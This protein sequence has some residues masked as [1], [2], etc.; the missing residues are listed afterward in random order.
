MQ[1]QTD[2]FC[3]KCGVQNVV[4]QIPENDNRPRQTC[5][6]C[7]TIFYENPRVIVGV[8]TTYQDQFLLCK[9]AI[10]PQ[11][12]LWTY[13]AG[14]LENGESI[15][16]GAIREA[17]EESE[18]KVTISRLLGTYTL[19]AVNQV[20]LIFSGVMETSHHAPT[21]ESSEVRLFSE[22][23]IPWNKLAFP[24]IKWALKA[25]I[26]SQNT[27]DYVVDSISSTAGY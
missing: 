10:E 16:A 21:F 5:L 26:N 12:G 22:A 1:K 24:V 15:E 13:P 4:Y 25:H 2:L 19:Q 23:E 7:D 14:F 3:A 27:E 8:V 11:S 20:H 18:A 17:Y 6:S 9:R